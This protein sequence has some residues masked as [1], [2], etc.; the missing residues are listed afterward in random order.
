MNKTFTN[1]NI[2]QDNLKAIL[3]HSL[4]FLLPFLTLISRFGVG[5]SSF[6]F[7]LTALL[8]WQAWRPAL[9]RHFTEVRWVLAAFLLSL[10]FALAGMLLHADIA[11][12][13]LE[14]P[15][16][17][18]LAV[19][20]LLAVL[21]L[22]PSR[23]ALWWGLIGGTLAGAAFICY[24]RWGLGIERPGGLINSITFGDIVLC[25]GLMSLAGVLDFKGRQVL[26]PW[27]GALAGLLGSVATGTRGGWIALLFAA[28][29]FIKYGH[30]LR[31]RL[32]RTLALL[33]LALLVSTY[34]IEGT[35]ARKRLHQGVSEVQTYIAG[36][37]AHTNIGLRLEL[38]KG[39]GMLIARHPWSIASPQQVRDELAEEVAAGRLHGFVTEYEHFHN[40]ILQVLVYGGVPGLLVWLGTLLAPFLFFLRILNSR[41]AADTRAAAPALA[42]M[43]LV[44]SYF[45]FGLTEVIFWSVRSSMFYALMLF[46]MMGLCLNAKD[47]KVAA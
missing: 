18:L 17:M 10:V 12:R 11:A 5:L 13:A 24:Q 34:F 45:S 39:A 26:W 27:L 2:L 33:A 46:L 28:V 6:G 44:L 42:G 23:K 1:K 21:A 3:I 31:G 7:L 8:F 43:L 38:W 30:Y 4:V 9:L 20:V 35:G 47:E 40:D 16:R 32:A 15:G 36:G 37:N 41:L 19:T 29:L 22:R 25:M 14:K